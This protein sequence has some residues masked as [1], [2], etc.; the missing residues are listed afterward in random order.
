MSRVAATCLVGASLGAFEPS[1]A[2][3]GGAA[4]GAA[5]PE[6]KNSA[7]TLYSDAL[8]KAEK[9]DHAGALAAFRASFDVVASPNTMLMIGKELLTLERYAEAHEALQES[10]E[11]A[12]AA[13]DPKYD[14]TKAQAADYLREVA[15]KIGVLRIDL[16]GRTGSVTV[17]G[18]AVSA[19]A[20]ARGVAA[21]PGE[22]EVE[23]AAPEGRDVRKVTAVAGQE[24]SLSFQKADLAPPPPSTTDSSSAA[25][26]LLIAGGVAGGIGVVGLGLF[27]AFG[28][29][30][31]GNESDFTEQCPGNVCPPGLREDVDSA[32]TQQTLANVG[33]IVGAAGLA[34]GAALLIPGVVL[35]GG[36]GQPAKTEAFFGPGSVVVR[37][38]F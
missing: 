20:L 16:A 27:A 21:S 26:P 13:A 35:S 17:A 30:T 1:E 9:K 38:S 24:A 28:A 4:V 25:T 37:T 14:K 34:I 15:P 5:T 32:K 3:A 11:I 23:L 6:Q 31:L 36:E 19:A 8:A 18:R 22:I 7:Q 12:T 10:I 2:A 29:M 33:A